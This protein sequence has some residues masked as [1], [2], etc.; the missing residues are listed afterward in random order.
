MQDTTLGRE[1]VFLPGALDMD[2]GRLVEAI[3]GMLK[4]REWDGV[5]QIRQKRPLN[6][7]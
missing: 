1:T 5:F 3:D 7:K 2:K 4:G 6:L